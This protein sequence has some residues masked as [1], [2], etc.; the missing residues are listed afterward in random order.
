M[1]RRSSRSLRLAVVALLAA[2]VAGC[3]ANEACFKDPPCRPCENPCCLTPLQKAALKKQTH[4]LAGGPVA[5]HYDEKT[6][7]LFTE[8][9]LED[10]E[11]DPDAFAEKGA[12]RLVR[13]GT[14]WRVDLNPGDDFDF[15]SVGNTATPYVRPPKPAKK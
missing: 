4:A 11:K 5:Y 15:V 1:S 8:T 2:V 12:I 7:I 9:G 10:F 13:G 6:Y 14:T 3:C